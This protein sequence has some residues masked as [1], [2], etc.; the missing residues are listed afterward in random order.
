MNLNEEKTPS[1]IKNFNPIFSSMTKRKIKL[2]ISDHSSFMRIAIR[3]MAESND[4]IEVVGEASNGVKAL[5]MFDELRPDAVVMDVT[6]PE[7]DGFKATREIMKRRPTP[8]IIVSGATNNQPELIMK[9]MGAGAVDF[10][11]KSTEV[12]DIDIANLEE[13]LINKIIYWAELPMNFQERDKLK[14]IKPAPE[15]KLPPAANNV[16]FTPKGKVGLVAIGVSTGGPK[17]LTDL[18]KPMGKLKCSVVVAQHM[19][20]TFTGAFADRLR[21]ETGLN[22]VEGKNNMPLEPEQIVIAPGGMDSI[23]RKNS[24]GELTL[25]VKRNDDEPVHP[26]VNMLF[27]SVIDAVEH[28]VA[29]ILTGMGNDGTEG[30]KKFAKKGRPVLVQ[31]PESCIV[32]GMPSSAIEAGAASEALSLERIG[33]RI[34]KWA[35]I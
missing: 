11:S 24:K 33:K 28:P 13:K 18:L 32:D 34:A 27:E 17:I 4:K 5:E 29:V 19:P 14:T 8:V 35:Q 12:A 7:T 16:N 2:L 15:L 30:A 31:E 26:S 10:L 9:S 6:L 20:G 21:E 23:V 3:K 1:F 22:V 25:H